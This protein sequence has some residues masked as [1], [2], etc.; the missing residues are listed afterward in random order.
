MFYDGRI[1]MLTHG[2]IFM[3]FM[4]IFMLTQLSILRSSFPGFATLKYHFSLKDGLMILV[5]LLELICTCI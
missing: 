3:L 1:F 5:L 2:R 4:V